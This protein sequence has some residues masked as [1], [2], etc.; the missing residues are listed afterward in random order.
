MHALIFYTIIQYDI[1]ILIIWIFIYLLCVI[2][3]L[4]LYCHWLCIHLLIYFYLIYLVGCNCLQTF[5]DG[6]D[7]YFVEKQQ[8]LRFIDFLCC[9]VPTRSK[10]S[11]K[12]VSADHSSNVAN[13]KHNFIIEIVPVCK[14]RC[15][16]S[17]GNT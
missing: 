12:L 14:V 16:F 10:Y 11:R 13:F 4:S 9:H 17:V 5:R 2:C 6:M 8:A 7:F 15:N 1:L 3:C